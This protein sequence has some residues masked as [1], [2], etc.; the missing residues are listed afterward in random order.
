MRKKKATAK[1]KNFKPIRL[2]KK[3]FFLVSLFLISILC[4]ELYF[5]SKHTSENNTEISQNDNSDVKVN[6]EAKNEDSSEK[7]PSKDNKNSSQEKDNTKNSEILSTSNARPNLKTVNNPND[8]KHLELPAVYESCKIIYN[9][10]GRYTVCYSSKDRQAY[11]VAYTLTSEDMSKKDAKRKDNFVPDPAVFSKNWKSATASDY[12]GSSY[13]RGHLVPSA[14]R[15]N[16]QVENDAT[17]LF[18]NIAPQAK[19]LNRFVWSALENEVR[20]LAAKYKTVYIATGGVL[21]YDTLA[22]IKIIGDSVTVPKMFYKVLLI[23]KDDEYYSI[24][25][26]MPNSEDCGRDYKQYAVTVDSVEKVTNIDFFYSLDDAIENKVESLI[27]N[28]FWN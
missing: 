24:G 27:D 9:K 11:W 1:S 10:N 21:N 4:I 23:E 2:S 25:Y 8:N 7:S 16:S 12:R 20:K 5:V 18:S 3:G 6:E 28:K 14:D 19:N 26:L 22:P 15:D 13:D 17:F